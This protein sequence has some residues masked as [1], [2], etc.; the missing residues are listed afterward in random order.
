MKRATYNQKADNS[1]YIFARIMG[2]PFELASYIQALAPV[3]GA[4]LLYLD[5]LELN[6]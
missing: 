1:K 5:F 2:T 6:F 3:W 4:F